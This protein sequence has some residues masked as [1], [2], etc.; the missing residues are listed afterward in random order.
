[1]SKKL[2]N[3][4]FKEICSFF[5]CWTRGRLLPRASCTPWKPPCPSPRDSARQHWSRLR[6]LLGLPGKDQSLAVCPEQ[7][8][9]PVQKTKRAPDPASRP[10]SHSQ[11]VPSKT[12][13]AWR[14][15]SVLTLIS[16]FSLSPLQYFPSIYRI[17]GSGFI[18][19]KKLIGSTGME[20]FEQKQ[21]LFMDIAM[22]YFSI[23]VKG[24][25]I[26]F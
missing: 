3:C 1:M 24:V 16:H 9:N 8:A 10:E 26:F 20:D 22:A 13:A 11:G 14:I 5:L 17:N 4:C 6:V 23:P 7:A 18:W 19:K 25:T 21:L 12:G 2:K 15:H